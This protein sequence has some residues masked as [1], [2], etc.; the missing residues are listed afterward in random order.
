MDNEEGEVYLNSYTTMERIGYDDVMT[1]DI[2]GNRFNKYV[3]AQKRV[4]EGQLDL[5]WEKVKIFYNHILHTVS[6]KNGR[7]WD[8]GRNFT[9]TDARM[10]IKDIY[11]KIIEPKFKNPRY[12]LFGILY[13]FGR[14]FEYTE[15]A[16]ME[17]FTAI[18]SAHN[19]DF[20]IGDVYRYI[21][22]TA[23]FFS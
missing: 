2:E 23:P 11:D 15:A 4:Q 16:I 12:L 10:N 9:W 14:K 21:R 8:I 17:Q 6:V 18:A 3:A 22:L 1:T 20:F 7:E 13:H 19:F 5:T